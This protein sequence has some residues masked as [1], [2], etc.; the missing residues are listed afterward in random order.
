LDEQIAAFDRQIRERAREDETVRR[1]MT[2]PGVGP[3]CATA[4]EALLA[5]L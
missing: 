5:P 1:L 4:L 3:V 2:I